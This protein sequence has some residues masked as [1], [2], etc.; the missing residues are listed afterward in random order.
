MDRQQ[1]PAP[2]PR[3]TRARTRRTKRKD[4]TD[5]STTQ[6]APTKPQLRLVVPP[7][8]GTPE[9]TPQGGQTQEQTQE[10]APTP[11][12]TP[13]EVAGSDP[14]PLVVP[15]CLKALSMIAAKEWSRY[16]MMGVRLVQLDGDGGFQAQVTDGGIAV[17]VQGTSPNKPPKPAATVQTALRHSAAINGTAAK[18]ATIPTRDWENGLRQAEKEKASHVAFAIGVNQTGIAVGDE[19]RL[20]DNLEGR[21]PDIK[22]VIPPMKPRAILN[23]NAARLERLCKVWKALGAEVMTVYLY[24]PNDPL[25]MSGRSGDGTEEGTLILSGLLMPCL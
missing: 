17:W 23:L 3:T 6:P 1:P 12:T 11:A 21:F 4:D 25:G 8:D 5:V 22:R 14:T 13:T 16:A 2:E 18:E 9:Q 24:G 19:L 20:A 7:L 15:T 10:T